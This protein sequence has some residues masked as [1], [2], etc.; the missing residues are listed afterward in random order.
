MVISDR[1]LDHAVW[2]FS[3]GSEVPKDKQIHVACG[4]EYKRQAGGRII[5]DPDPLGTP[6]TFSRCEEETCGNIMQ[7]ALETCDVCGSMASPFDLY[8][9]KGFM[10][11]GRPRDYDGQRQRGPALNPPVLAFKPDYASG[12]DVGPMRATLTS[13]EPIALVNDAGGEL[14]KFR[15]KFN[16]IVVNDDYLYRDDPPHQDLQGEPETTGAIGAVFNTDVMTLLLDRLAA[17]RPDQIILS[18]LS[19]GDHALSAQLLDP[20]FR[21]IKQLGNRA[22]ELGC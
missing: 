14:F 8:Q 10:T 19:L 13:D 18:A 12:F 3:P 16:S 7:G 9:P 11:T 5:S 6:L 4:F 17:H 2:A 22:D 15:R 1:P 21:Q 20:P